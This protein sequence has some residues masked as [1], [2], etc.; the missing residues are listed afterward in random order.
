M[1]VPASNQW[2]NESDEADYGEQ[3][4]AYR[5]GVHALYERVEVK[6]VQA[7]IVALLR[8]FYGGNHVIIMGNGGHGGTA[9]HWVND[10][11]K[12]TVVNDSKTS[13]VAGERRFKVLSLVDNVSL[14]T[15]WANDMGYEQAFAQQL[16]NWVQPEDVVIGISGS[17]NS[18][19][20]LAAFD[21]AN[22]CGAITFAMAGTDG[23]T[24][25]D[26]AQH[27]VLVPSWN[28]LMVEDVHFSL[29]HS[30]T[31]SVRGRIQ[32]RAAPGSDAESIS[33]DGLGTT[34]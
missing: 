6:E 29:T 15:A 1:V 4:R 8:A 33:A 24:M 31:A 19:N 14:L 7:L 34:K 20:I 26:V 2:E 18:R 5:S 3:V 21:S 28:I 9:S 30:I 23:G 12:H 16:A 17:G 11:S 32:A 10:L 27:T 25:K 22:A 13:V